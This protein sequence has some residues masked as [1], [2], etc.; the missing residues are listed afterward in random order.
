MGPVSRACLLV[1]NVTL[2]L[3]IQEWFGSIYWNLSVDQFSRYVGILLVKVYHNVTGLMTVDLRKKRSHVNGLVVYARCNF[4][5]V[6]L[7]SL[8]QGYS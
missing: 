5:G 6:T 7:R 3:I 4:G 8:G 1:A 2:A